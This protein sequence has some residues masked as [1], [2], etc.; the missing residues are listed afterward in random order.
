MW[1]KEAPLSVS[2]SETLGGMF[3]TRGVL[4]ILYVPSSPS[5]IIPVR[6]PGTALEKHICGGNKYPRHGVVRS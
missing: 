2:A 1:C 5:C 4:C 6:Q 3:R